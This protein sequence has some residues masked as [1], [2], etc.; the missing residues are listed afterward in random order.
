MSGHITVGDKTIPFEGDI[1][2][3]ANRTYSVDVGRG[4]LYDMGFSVEEVKKHG[5]VIA[6]DSPSKIKLV[7]S[8]KKFID[9][10]E[11]WQKFETTSWLLGSYVGQ[12]D[13]Y[14]LNRMLEAMINNR[15]MEYK[16]ENGTTYYRRTP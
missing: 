15:V 5:A 10:M 3:T 2:V 8:D 4:D 9:C 13:C 6:V 7:E 11:H 12:F 14:T 1:T 16:T